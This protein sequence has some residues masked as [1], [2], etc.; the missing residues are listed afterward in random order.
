MLQRAEN[1]SDRAFFD[2]GGLEIYET[3]RQPTPQGT[4]TIR[5]RRQRVNRTVLTESGGA[6][7]RD[8]LLNRLVQRR[9]VRP[10]V[11]LAWFDLVGSSMV[12]MQLC[13]RSTLTGCRRHSRWGAGLPG[14]V[15]IR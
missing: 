4:P 14:V 1:A 6:A 5:D 9:N 12:P 3:L 11:V 10:V 13:S 8:Q 15:G 7:F 2:H